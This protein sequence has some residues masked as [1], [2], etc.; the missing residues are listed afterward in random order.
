[1]L[2]LHPV[3]I[4]LSLGRM[5]R[6]LTA[7]DH[8]ERKLPPVIH[9]AGTNGKGST[10]AM[11]RAGLAAAGQRVHA[12]TS[13]HLV[14]FSERIVL[15]GAEIDEPALID[16][17]HRTLMANDG[18]PIT[19][20]EAT[21]CAAFLAFAENPADMLL[22]EVG[23]GGRLDATNVIDCPLCTVITPVDIDHQE[24]LGDTLAKIA[25][26]KAGI[27]KR[28]VP[29]II[30]RQPDEALDVIEARATPLGAPISAFGQQWHVTTE[31]GRLVFQD[32]T[33]LLDLP[34]PALPG[35]HQVENAGIAL[36][37]LRQLGHGE[38]A[39]EAAL[40][41]AAWPA[42]IQRLTNGPL[43]AL[44]PGM[45]LW[46]DGGHN[47][48]AGRALARAMEA[49][50]GRPLWMITG[51]MARKDWAGF[52]APFGDVVQGVMA[53]PVTDAPGGAAPEDVAGAARS[54]GLSVEVSGSVT[55][56]LIAIAAKAPGAR[57]LICGSLYLAGE[58]LALQ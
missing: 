22:L 45:E 10:L 39:C 46:L 33:G 26:E 51:M 27:L 6:L 18:H 31:H 28:G 29:C 43:V 35:L 9:I 1:M 2:A 34:L 58:V 7:L 13:P 48:A 37:V 4:E 52:L 38:A 11:V 15:N 17:L 36:A 40:R 47:P 23:L 30:G 14:R 16:V 20:F 25:G 12:Y 21:T 8:P 53:V 44:A 24:F 56:A 55:D 57:V 50:P 54:V 19:Y 3:E 5:T 41:D 42:R 49:M 32:E